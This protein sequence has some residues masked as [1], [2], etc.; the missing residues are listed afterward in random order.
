MLHANSLSIFD[1]FL[2]INM[3]GLDDLLIII[4]RPIIPLILMFKNFNCGWSNELLSKQDLLRKR[5]NYFFI[6]SNLQL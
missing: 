5:V 1:N 4:G 3:L 6:I 2:K